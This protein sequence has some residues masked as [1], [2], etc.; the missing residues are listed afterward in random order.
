MA[1]KIK[2]LYIDDEPI[3]TELFKI[4]FQEY[5]QVITALS[6][7]EGLEKLHHN[8][9]I[10]VIITDMKMPGMNG[11]EFIVKAREKYPEKIYFI[12]SGYDMSEEIEIALQ[13][14]V[15]KEYFKKPF[16]LDQ[17]NLAIRNCQI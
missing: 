15:I 17:I 14:K 8:D 10:S 11:M 2:V 7:Q 5:Y 3:N 12:L 16:N 13:K 1:D 6:G 9:D 4:N